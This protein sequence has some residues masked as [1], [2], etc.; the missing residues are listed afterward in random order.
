MVR[1]EIAKAGDLSTVE[2][3][4]VVLR[5]DLRAGLRAGPPDP[6]VRLAGH[7][8]VGRRER[9]ADPAGRRPQARVRALRGDGRELPPRDGRQQRRRGDDYE[10]RVV[11]GRTGRVIIDGARPQRVGAALGVTARRALRG[12]RRATAE[13]AG[14]T[15]IAGHRTAYRRIGST[16]GNANDWIVVAS[17]NGAD[18]QLPLGRRPGADRDARVALL[19]IALA[20]V[21]LRA[22]PP[23]ARGAGDHGRA[24]R[25]GQPPQAARRPRAPR[26]DGARAEA[27]VGAD[28]VRPQRVQELQ[29]HLRPSR[30]RRAAAAPRRRARGGRRA[31][32]AAAPTGPGGDEFCVIAGAAH[33]HAIEQAA[34]RA[35]SEHGEGFAISAAFG[36]VV[37]PQDTGDVDRGDAQGRR[38]DVRAEALRPRDRRAPEQR[39]ADARARR[40]PPRPRRPPRRRRRARR[41]GRATGWASTATSSRSS[42]TPHRCT[43]SAR[44][45]S[46]TRSSPSPAR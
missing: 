42:A 9:D 7:E 4:T 39:R 33:Q 35:L 23:R 32:S 37:I 25:A 24:D 18:R 19:I 5:A 21:S 17:A 15:E 34:C 12:A 40:A 22:A 27:P 13:S 28:D 45:R 31:R 2:E 8:G 41:R 38:G 30:R 43:T 1:G 16:A 10:L 14:V 44:S 20:G 26:P 11:D 29:R 6:A 36:S 3:Q 46:R